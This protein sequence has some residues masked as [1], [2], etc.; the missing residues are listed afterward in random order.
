MEYVTFEVPAQ[1][2]L[3]PVIAPAA[4]GAPFTVTFQVAGAPVNPQLFVG[5]AVICPE[6]AVC[7]STVIFVVPCPV[8]TEASAGTVQT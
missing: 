2:V 7:Q 3:E 5:V 6:L 1:T 4:P 8:T